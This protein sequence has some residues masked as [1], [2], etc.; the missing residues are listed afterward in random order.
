VCLTSRPFVCLCAPFIYNA[1]PCGEPNIWHNY[2]FVENRSNQSGFTLLELMVTLVI[3]A[4]LGFL[5]IP[6]MTDMIRN[7]RIAT[8][9]NDFLAD[10]SFAR[11]EA[12]KRGTNVGVCSGTGAACTGGSFS[13]GW[14]VFVDTASNQV[15]DAGVDEIIR[16]RERPNDGK[17]T[18]NSANTVIVF[19]ARGLV[20]A[21]SGTYALCDD[22]GASQ[23]RDILI[24]GTGQVRIQRPAAACL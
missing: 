17:T 3:A 9:A 14:L 22:R 21:G 15:F 2:P 20:S 8:Q 13:A 7:H 10:L 16:R 6:A 19:S 12:I 18:L 11:S 1:I 4:I 5:A 23:G 24:S